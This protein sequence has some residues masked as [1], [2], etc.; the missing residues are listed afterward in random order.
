MIRVLL[1]AC[2]IASGAAWAEQ[3]QDFGDYV[4]HYNAQNTSDLSPEVARQYSLSRNAR[5]AM[6]MVTVQ[7]KSGQAVAASVSGTARNLLGQSQ[8]LELRE[9]R[10]GPSIYYLGLFTISNLET[11]TFEIDIRP[12]KLKTPFRLRFSQQ[13][14]V[15]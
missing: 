12:E 7:Q 13:F 1:L 11:Q 2:V 15:N 6:V 10:E 5:L 14:F 3:K 4:V 8:P 9:V